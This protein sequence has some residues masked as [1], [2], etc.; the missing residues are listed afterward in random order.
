MSA[1]IELLLQRARLGD[2]AARD[3][4]LARYQPLIWRTVGHCRP[5]A[6]RSSFDVDDLYQQA[7]QAFLELI[8]EYDPSR[9]NGFGPYVK[10][11]IVLRVKNCLRAHRRRRRGESSY[12]GVTLP[13]ALDKRLVT[14]LDVDWGVYEVTNPRLRAALARLSPK[15]RNILSLLYGAD[16]SVK[17][18]AAQLGISP[19]AVNALRARAEARLRRALTPAEG[20][21]VSGAGCREREPDVIRQPDAGC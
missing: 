1:P 17:E 6:A 3:E 13:P 20:D 8:Q 10:T 2:T 14:H 19:R 4:L 16:R 21:R 11:M 12:Y 15:Q 9:S 7:V 5:F 18:V